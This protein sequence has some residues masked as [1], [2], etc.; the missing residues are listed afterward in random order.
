MFDAISKHLTVRNVLI[1]T[2]AVAAVGGLV[3][4]ATRSDAV[5]AT[6]DVLQAAGES[7]VETGSDLIQQAAN[8]TADVAEKVADAA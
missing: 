4:W 3:Y 7:M 5:P 2:A 1:G 8:A 6:A